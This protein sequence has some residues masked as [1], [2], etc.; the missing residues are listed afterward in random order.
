MSLFMSQNFFLLAIS[1]S[2]SSTV[3]HK[4]KI[5]QKIFGEHKVITLGQQFLGVIL[6]FFMHLR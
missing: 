1:M 5:T 6:S 3:E 2:D 4:Q